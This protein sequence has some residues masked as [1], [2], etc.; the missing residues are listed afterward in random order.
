M[1]CCPGRLAGGFL[2][3]VSSDTL[4]QA[5]EYARERAAN[6]AMA[7]GRPEWA[8]V[9]TLRWHDFRHEAISR[10]FDA[11]W[12]AE[13]VMDVSSHVDIKSLLRYRHPKIAQTVARLRAME[14]SRQPLKQDI[15]GTLGAALRNGRVQLS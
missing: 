6:R 8:T 12:H 1:T 4:K 2:F 14:A 7:I 11:K 5:F 3:K 9:R 15:P 10:L 13:E